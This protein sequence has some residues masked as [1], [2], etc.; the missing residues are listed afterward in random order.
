MKLE[1]SLSDGLYI[2]VSNIRKNFN[3]PPNGFRYSDDFKSLALSINFTSPVTYRLMRET[4][5]LPSEKTLPT[6]I[7]AWP[8]EPGNID[9]SIKSLEL[10]MIQCPEIYK[11]CSIAMDE[12]SLKTHLDYCRKTDKVIGF[13]DFGSDELRTSSPARNV[14]II[15]A[16]GVAK[17][18]KHPLTYFFVQSSCPSVMLKKLLIKAIYSLQKSGFVPVHFVSDQGAN[19]RGLHSDLG[20][21]RQKPYFEV[22]HE[23]TKAVE[24]I[25]CFYDAPHL[26]KST[27]NCLKGYEVSFIHFREYFT[28]KWKDIENFH[29]I[30]KKLSLRCAPKITKEHIAPNNFQR[31][32]VRYATQVFSNT[33]G[34]GLL[35]LYSSG[36]GSKF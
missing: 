32:K 19:F 25:F 11:Q 31:M 23:V 21:C 2:I 36:K 7:S 12:M 1:K 24:K 15:M 5:R 9:F 30:D 27:R 3:K 33:L 6:F 13:Q 29:N 18:W 17:R 20:I 10:K 26:I 35:N 16:Q 4:L 22:E 34:S 8:R 28:A 14:L